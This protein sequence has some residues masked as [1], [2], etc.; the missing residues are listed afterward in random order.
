[1][2]GQPSNHSHKPNCNII[3]YSIISIGITSPESLHAGTNEM[4]YQN[5]IFYAPTVYSI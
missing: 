1:M 3:L 5:M 2:K 4:H